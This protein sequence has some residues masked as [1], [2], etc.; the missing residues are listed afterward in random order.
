M[1]RLDVGETKD[2]AGVPG[3]VARMIS[4]P[5]TSAIFARYSIVERSRMIGAS[6]YCP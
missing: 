6:N 1:L 5:K 2:D 4:G 3:P